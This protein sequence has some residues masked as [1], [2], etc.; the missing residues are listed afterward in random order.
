MFLLG[1]GIEAG[2][3]I[4][5]FFFCYLESLRPLPWYDLVAISLLKF[6]VCFWNATHR[7]FSFIMFLKAKLEHYLHQ[8]HQVLHKMPIPEPH[9]R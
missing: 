6:E 1:N 4:S 8:C 5:P 2:E 9:P 3:Y 7:T